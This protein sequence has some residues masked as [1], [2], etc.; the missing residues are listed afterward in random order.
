MY[1]IIK[2]SY[3]TSVVS[4]NELPKIRNAKREFAIL[5]ASKKM[6]CNIELIKSITAYKQNFASPERDLT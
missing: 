2:F 1:I 4:T 6:A 3:W 5:I